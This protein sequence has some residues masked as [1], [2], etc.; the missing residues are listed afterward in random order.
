M[1]LY[2]TKELKVCALEKREKVERSQYAHNQEGMYFGVHESVAAA[3]NKSDLGV[4]TIVDIRTS[5]VLP[6]GIEVLEVTYY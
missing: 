6:G 1:K 3:L 4:A 2:N 5:R